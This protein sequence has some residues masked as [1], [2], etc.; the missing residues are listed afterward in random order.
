MFDG[1]ATQQDAVRASGAP[2]DAA[3]EKKPAEMAVPAA[4]AAAAAA[5]AAADVAAAGQLAADVQS[6]IDLSVL[7]ILEQLDPDHVQDYFACNDYLSSA[8]LEAA[9]N[10]SLVELQALQQVLAW[11]LQLP[12]GP[13]RGRAIYVLR[14]ADGWLAAEVLGCGS[15]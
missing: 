9:A 2:P 8:V 4:P 14:Q 13:V 15:V 10:A 7:L 11:L 12:A 1:L 3:A 5:A 6:D